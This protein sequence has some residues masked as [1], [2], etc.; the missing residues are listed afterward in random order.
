MCM[1]LIVSFCEVVGKEG[2]GEVGGGGP[3]QPQ[4]RVA[5]RVVVQLV[6]GEVSRTCRYAGDSPAGS[7]GSFKG[8]KD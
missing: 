6:F 1:I 2:L 5:T 3:R 4:G 7:R 8:R